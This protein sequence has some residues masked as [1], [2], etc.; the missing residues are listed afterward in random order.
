MHDAELR[1]SFRSSIHCDTRFSLEHHRSRL[2]NH[3]RNLVALADFQQGTT[4]LV[5]PFRFRPSYYLKINSVCLCQYL[6]VLEHR[7][8]KFLRIQSEDM[9]RL[10]LDASREN[11][12]MKTLSEK[13]QDDAQIMRILTS[14]AFLFMPANLIA[15]SRPVISQFPLC[16]FLIY[17]TLPWR[18]LFPNT[19][20]YWPPPVKYW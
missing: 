17:P 13:M 12:V 9:S 8:D 5:S 14:I 1:K 4:T 3:R 11:A 2:Q 20:H 19:S 18:S 6:K 15:V 10:A 16:L 7:H